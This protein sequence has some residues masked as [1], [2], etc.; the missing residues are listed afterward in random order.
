VQIVEKL[1]SLRGVSIVRSLWFRFRHLRNLS[2]RRN[3]FAI[4]LCRRAV[5]ELNPGAV[6]ELRA[7]SLRLGTSWARFARASTLLQLSPRSRVVLH[8]DMRIHTGGSIYL[9]E[10][11][12]LEMG[13]G[14]LNEDVRIGCYN[15]IKIGHDVAI[16]EQVVIRDSD[17]HQLVGGPAH[18]P[19]AP[20]EI[21]NHV[22]IG[23]RATIL[24]GVRI[25][26]G[27]V[28]AAG[29]VVTRDVPAYSIVA[30]VPARVVRENIRWS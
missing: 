4:R 24:K 8:G 7:G 29:A 19:D 5:I 1:E 18:Q 23:M 16:A 11:A 13:S 30:G 15:H 12:V 3:I 10:G 17:N 20:I 14:Y 22:W 9:S 26:D 6:V 21:G 2:S 25:G 28:V 27:A